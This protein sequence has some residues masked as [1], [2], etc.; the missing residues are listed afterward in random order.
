MS[1]EELIPSPPRAGS[2]RLARLLGR[3]CSQLAFGSLLLRFP[4]G[5]ARLYRGRFPGPAGEMS[6]RRPLQLLVRLIARGEIGFAESYMEGD[7]ETPDL[8]A[9]LDALSL[10]EEHLG[11]GPKGLP[12]SRWLDRI[13]HRLRDNRRSNSRRNIARHYDLGNDFYRLWLDPG[14]TYSAALFRDRF[15]DWRSESLE[16]A[17]ARKYARLLDDLHARPGD[18]VLEIGCGWGG[19]A[20]AAAERGLRVTGVTL[21]R[22]Q[23]AYARDR[24]AAAGLADRVELRLQ[25]YRDIRGQFDHA[26]SIEMLEAVGE[27]YWPT[28]FQALRRLVRPGGRISLQAIAMNEDD[29][30]R[31]RRSADFIQLYIFPGGML[32]SPE[33]IQAEALAAGLQPVETR[34]FGAHYAETLRR[35]RQRFRAAEGE[36]RRLGYDGRF[37]RMWDY[38]LAYCEVGFDNGTVDLAQSVLRVPEIG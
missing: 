13:V 16:A 33:R 1:A 31:Y 8:V 29:F 28:Y 19:F 18:Q 17:Q 38:Y 27:S 10:N 7:W 14:M 12:G 25:D 21:S 11:A 34:W 15:E 5:G 9:L 36:V 2:D 22:E 6:I 30:P 20:Q 4:D 24:I 32:P 26:V 3:F 23:L 35:W 37:R